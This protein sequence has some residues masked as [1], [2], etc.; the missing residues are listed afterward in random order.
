MKSL[1]RLFLS[2]PRQGK[3]VHEKIKLKEVKPNKKL[4]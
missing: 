2:S 1:S 3:K 4:N